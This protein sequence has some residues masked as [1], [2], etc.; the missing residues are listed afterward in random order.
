MFVGWT[1]CIAI[2]N[3]TKNISCNT[4]TLDCVAM[5][6]LLDNTCYTPPYTPCAG[7]HLTHGFMTAKKR[8]SATSVYFE[9]MPYRLDEST[10]LIDYDALAKS[11]EMFKPKLIIAGASAYSRNIDYKR[12]KEIA[13][14][15]MLRKR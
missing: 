9:S 3:A 7:G 1:L 10:G 12:M 4:K 6:P 8:V 14:K 2:H 5:Q 11:A 13:D 15:V